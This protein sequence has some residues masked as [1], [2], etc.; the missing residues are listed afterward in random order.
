MFHLAASWHGRTTSSELP[1]PSTTSSVLLEMSQP[2]S[3][4]PPLPLHI[5]EDPV[6]KP[7]IRA[8][9]AQMVF[10]SRSSQEFIT[11][12]H[13]VQLEDWTGQGVLEA[14][15]GFDIATDVGQ[16]VHFCM[17]TDIK[18]FVVEPAP[19]GWQRM[20]IRGA[21]RMKIKRLLPMYTS[22]TITCSVY[23]AN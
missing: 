18:Y 8:A 14:L 5:L 2:S 3:T 20:G 22:A 21:H 1:P 11:P 10:A 12:E 17:D 7:K 6:C 19:R 15:R 16:M 9:A 4:Q 23:K 13:V